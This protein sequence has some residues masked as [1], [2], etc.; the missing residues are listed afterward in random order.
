M[1]RTIDEAKRVAE[2]Y[3]AAHF[4]KALAVLLGGSWARGEAHADSDLDIVILDETVDRVLFEG[5]QFEDWIVD[6]CALNP[7]HA[8]VFFDDS[9]RYRDAPIPRQVVDAIVVAGDPSLVER[10]RELAVDA[11]NRGP[12]PLSESERIDARFYLTLLRQ[13]LVHAS[14]EALPALAAYAHVQ[15][16]KAA[17]DAGRRWRAERKNLRRAVV[18]LDPGLAKDLDEALA[19]AVG[20]RSGPMVELCTRV[21]SLLGGPLRTYER[22]SA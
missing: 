7:G 21:L 2:R 10:I 15:L 22:F 17:L 20:G 9:A 13:D 5:V 16:S 1:N 6:V 19:E 11:L 14:P 18:D 8:Q 12:E 4:P 3:A